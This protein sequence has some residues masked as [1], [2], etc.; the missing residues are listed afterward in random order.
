MTEAPYM[1]SK[2][3]IRLDCE[4]IRADWSPVE[5]RRRFVG[6]KREHVDLRAVR[7]IIQEP[8]GDE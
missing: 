6:K 2:K 3:Q 5:L 1:P 4:A 8:E 7:S